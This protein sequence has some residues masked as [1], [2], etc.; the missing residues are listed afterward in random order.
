VPLQEGGA[1]RRACVEA[2]LVAEGR[3]AVWL[4]E[5]RLVLLSI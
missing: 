5:H 4:Q 2:A 1:L 3:M